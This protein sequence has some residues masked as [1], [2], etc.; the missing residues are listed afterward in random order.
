MAIYMMVQLASHAHRLALHAQ[1]EFVIQLSARKIVKLAAV[2]LA[3]RVM[4]DIT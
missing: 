3:F 1:M 2:Q 4:T